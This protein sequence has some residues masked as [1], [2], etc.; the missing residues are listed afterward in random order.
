MTRLFQEA[1]LEPIFVE[2]SVSDDEEDTSGRV[3]PDAPVAMPRE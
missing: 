2:L 1:P 3:E